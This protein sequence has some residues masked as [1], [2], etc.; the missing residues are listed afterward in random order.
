METLTERKKTT[1]QNAELWNPV[2]V[3]I[4]KKAFLH[5]R[6]RNISE[7]DQG[8]SWETVS[9]NNIRNYTQKSQQYDHL[10]VS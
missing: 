5:L 4:S 6:F 3:D 7:E 2:P 8:I 10:D 1:S 9:P